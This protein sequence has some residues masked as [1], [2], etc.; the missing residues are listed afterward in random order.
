MN[1]R[2]ILSRKGGVAWLILLWVGTSAAQQLP[3]E[4]VRWADRVFHNGIVLTV[5]TDEGDFTVAQAL[6][7]RDG[8]I[9]AVGSNDR[10]LRLAGPRTPRVDLNGKAVMPGIVDTHVHPN[11]EALSNFF[12]ELPPEYQRLLQ[13]D[14]RIQRW[15]D[16]A[17][18]LEE[19]K[20]IVEGHHPA[21]EWV[22]INYRGGLN[23][24]ARSITRFDLDALSPDKPLIISATGH[25]GMVN[26][27]GLDQLF[28]VYPEHRVPGLRRDADGVPTGQLDFTIYILR[29]DILPQVP[30]AVL[31]P[32][33]LKELRENLSPLGHTTFSSRLNA[34]EIRAYA[35]L[36]VQ[37]KLPVRLAYGDEV[38]RWNP[39]FERD[40]K[41]NL[42]AVMTF[43][44]DRMWMNA[45]TVAPPDGSPNTGEVCSSWVKRNPEP[46]DVYGPDGQC[47]WDMDNDMT[48]EAVK[49][50]IDE[51][52]RIANIHTYGDK[53]NERAVDLFVEMG[54]A[55][56]RWGLDHSGLFNPDLIRKSGEIGLYWSVSAGKFR[57]DFEPIAEVYGREVAH[58]MLFPLKALVD[59]GAKVT[60][61]TSARRGR[62]T[63]TVFKDMQMFV[64]RRSG[65]GNVWG[66]RHALDRKTALRMMTRWG[67][68]YVMME[69]K[70]GSLEPGKFADLIVLNRN[71]LD[72]SLPDD[73]LSEVRVLLTMM[74]GEIM[75]NTAESGL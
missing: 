39:V 29:T 37:G 75:Y 35:L 26:S 61:E 47:R 5:D 38:G 65:E 51:G 68:E 3:D 70:I 31:A 22:M 59:A 62:G 30:A 46:D 23:E 53:G 50:I 57:D 1:T 67:A 40:M 64:T 36:D 4:V 44:S 7:I 2:G 71:P 16:K 13:A 48:R 52:F 55:D 73:Q 43:G 69:D 56:R 49:L 34:N 25:K 63:K 21:K 6:A 17:Q 12:D 32:I 58:N 54:G 45:I 28:D 19:I 14:G 42:G 10:I 41:R 15:D 8:K 18:V 9:L 72:P 66:L 27:K 11:R 60:Y 74:G 24:V 20:R 33:F